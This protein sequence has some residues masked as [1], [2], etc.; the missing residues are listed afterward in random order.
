M[1][2][3]LLLVDDEAVIRTLLAK[4]FI[5]KGYEVITASDG[6]EALTLLAQQRVDIVVTDLMMPNMDGFQLLEQLRIDHPLIRVIVMTGA[7]SLEN[8]LSCLRD[9]AFSFVCKPLDD[10]S[11]LDDAIHVAAW[12]V[13]RWMEQL[14]TLRRMKRAIETAP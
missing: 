3:R 6:R 13:Q 1:A 7:V 4:H 10:M 2:I 11:P 8:M 9:G 12:V 5:N 14:T